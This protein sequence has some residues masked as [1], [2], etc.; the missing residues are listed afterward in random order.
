MNRTVT[1]LAITFIT[2]FAWAAAQRASD[3]YMDLTQAELAA[4]VGFPLRV[5][6]L[7]AKARGGPAILFW[8]YYQRSPSGGIEEKEFGFQHVPLKVCYISSGIDA[9]RFLSLERDRDSVE[10]FR[11]NARHGR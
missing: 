6:T 5:Y 4:K 10:I 11:Y 8:V 7:P 9:S 2:A 3:N 1:A